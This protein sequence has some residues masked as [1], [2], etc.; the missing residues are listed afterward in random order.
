VQSSSSAK[1]SQE[2]SNGSPLEFAPFLPPDP[3]HFDYDPT[4]YDPMFLDPT[5]EWDMETMWMP[6][7]ATDPLD[8][9]DLMGFSGGAGNDYG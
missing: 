5:F 9:A 4:L 7:F 3:S 2:S 6:S 8:S 1:G